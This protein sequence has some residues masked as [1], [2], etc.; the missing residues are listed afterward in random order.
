VKLLNLSN[1][2]SGYA[3]AFDQNGK[4]IKLKEVDSGKLGDKKYP[5]VKLY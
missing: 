2:Y 3:F 1:K 5:N 4:Q